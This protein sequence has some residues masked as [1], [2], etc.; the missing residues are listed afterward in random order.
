MKIA[1]LGAECTGKTS[2]A[3]TLMSVLQTR[4][5]STYCAP[6]VLREW[7]DQHD[8]TPQ[9]FEQIAIAHAS[10]QRVLKAPACDVLLADTTPVMTAIYSDIVLGDPSL[11]P[12]AL[13]H[14]TVYD[15]T[16]VTGLDLPWVADGIQRDGPAMQRRVDARLR[17]VLQA[18]GLRYSVVYGQ[19]AQRSV[20]ALAALDH[21]VQQAATGPARPDLGQVRWQWVC[22]KCSDA[23][24]EHQLFSSLLGR[25]PPPAP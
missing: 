15:L 1:L 20:C 24:C 21:C 3:Q 2:L 9:A 19:G 17:E 16:L 12:F 7:C 5:Q 25:A 6:E 11:Y 14:H 8:R 10:A 18:H 23:Q 22:D 13:A 4:G